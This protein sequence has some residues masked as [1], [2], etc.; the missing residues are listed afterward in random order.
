MAATKARTT[1]GVSL[2]QLL[3]RLELRVLR[4]RKIILDFA[5]ILCT[6]LLFA[7]RCNLSSPTHSNRV[8]F[9]IPNLS[10]YI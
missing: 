8:S 1:I 6:V 5:G 2:R 3:Y 10:I 4:E 9:Y 7:N